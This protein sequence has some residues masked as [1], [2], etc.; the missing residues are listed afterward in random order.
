MEVPAALDPQFPISRCGGGHLGWVLGQGRQLVDDD[1]DPSVPQGLLNGSRIEGAHPGDS[2]SH[3]GE[4]P[5]PGLGAGH[6]RDL[7]A[8]ADQLGDERLA[9]RSACPGDEDPHGSLIARP[10]AAAAEFA[11]WTPPRSPRVASESSKVPEAW[12]NQASGKTRV[13]AL[14]IFRSAKLKHAFAVQVPEAGQRATVGQRTP[15][16]DSRQCGSPDV[17]DFFYKSILRDQLRLGHADLDSVRLRTSKIRH[18]QGAL[19]SWGTH[20]TRQS[21]PMLDGGVQRSAFHHFRDR[22]ASRR[23]SLSGSVSAMARSCGMTA[24]PT[25]SPRRRSPSTQTACLRTRTWVEVVPRNASGTSAGE[26]SQ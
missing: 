22:A 20:Q 26:I 5:R 4:V 21:A 3:I 11:S 15:V 2:G 9:D 25:E 14:T 12:T 13:S 6:S 24:R 7:V 23:I 8:T 19:P 16:L 18:P 1:L 10:A 17:A